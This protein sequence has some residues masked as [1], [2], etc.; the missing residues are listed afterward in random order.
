VVTAMTDA[1]QLNSVV[2]GSKTGQCASL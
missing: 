2:S 1:G